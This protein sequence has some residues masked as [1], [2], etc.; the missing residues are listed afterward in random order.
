[1][2]IKPAGAAVG[3]ALEAQQESIRTQDEAIERQEK[4]LQAQSAEIEELRRGYASDTQ[5]ARP[6]GY[7]RDTGDRLSERGTSPASGASDPRSARFAEQP[8][9][10]PVRGSYG[11]Q[12]NAPIRSPSSSQ[13]DA[14]RVNQPAALTPQCQNAQDEITRASQSGEVSEKLFHYRRAL[15]LCP[16]N[17]S[18][19][20][21]LGE[22]YLSMNRRNDAEYEFREALRLDPNY[23]IARDNL[24]SLGR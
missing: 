13:V 4:T 3:N 20:N 16:D 8:A 18:F 12:E 7:H 6:P 19:H 10:E 22:L 5:S 24:N 23:A 9:R 11:W 21:G 17:P 15:R 2:E 14:A 1:M